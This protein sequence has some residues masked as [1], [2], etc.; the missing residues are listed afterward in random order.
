MLR[1]R[2]EFSIGSFAVRSA[3]LVGSKAVQDIL[4]SLLLIWLAR[5][6][7]SGYGLT[8]LGMSA[9]MLLRALQ[10]M[11]MDQY[12]LR[13]LSALDSRRGALLRKMARVKII[14]IAAVITVFLGFSFF[15]QWP[16][17][18]S[19]VVFVL[20]CGQGLEGLSDTFF[21]MLRAEGRNINESV[22]RTGPNVIA[23]IYGAGCLLFQLDIVFFALMFPFGGAMKLVASIYSAR[24][25]CDFKFFKGESFRLDSSALLALV[26]ISGVSF[27]GTFYN[28]IQIFW[29]KNYYNTRRCGALSGCPRCHHL[30][31]RGVCPAHCRS[32]FV[33]TAGS[34]L[35]QRQR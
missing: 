23:S 35:F 12:T 7:P 14:I 10:S 24:R 31:L 2:R 25:L 28:E 3:A 32:G 34:D 1:I 22:C 5:L 4:A 20:L 26:T 33:P 29:L 15:R 11:G 30:C 9:A 18:H 8:V 17:E 6:D 19:V 13:E 21:N 27:L 16:Q